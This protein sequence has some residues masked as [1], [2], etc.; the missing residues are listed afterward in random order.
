M[1][2]GTL[3]QNIALGGGVFLKKLNQAIFRML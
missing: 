2:N 1:K 3:V